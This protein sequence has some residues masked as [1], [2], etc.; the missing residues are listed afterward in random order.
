MNRKSGGAAPLI[1]PRFDVRHW[2]V[3]SRG[4]PQTTDRGAGAYE[5]PMVALIDSGVDTTHPAF[6]G[7]R[8]QQ[9]NFTG[10]SP[11]VDDV[12]HGTHCAGLLVGQ[13]EGGLVGLAPGATLLSA[14]IF[15]RSK[16]ARPI[17]TALV[18][19]LRWALDES[20]DIIVLPLGRREACPAV[21]RAVEQAMDAGVSV[22]AAAGNHGGST[23]L[24][25]ASV[26]GVI[27]ASALGVD[28]WPL[29]EC[30]AGEAVDAFVLAEEVLSAHPTGWRHMSGSSQA[31]AIL[32]GLMARRTKSAGGDSSQTHV[33]EKCNKNQ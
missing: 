15:G 8:I 4:G 30:Y 19:A 23:P 6:A 11:V 9:R 28:G 16:A 12:G 31:A 18:E 21:L 2:L 17:A 22:V 24:F 14:K 25:P 10:G 26:D 27:C 7:A 13:S 32:G 20:A 5:M 29:P 1:G 33:R 3:S